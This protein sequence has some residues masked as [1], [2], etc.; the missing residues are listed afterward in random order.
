MLAPRPPALLLLLVRLLLLAP[1]PIVA[2]RKAEVV[3]SEGNG[4]A[5]RVAAACIA[6]PLP[7]G[8]LGDGAA[9]SG[10]ERLLEPVELGASAAQNAALPRILHSKRR[11]W[12]SS[13]RR[14]F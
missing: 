11:S 2:E 12:Y 7:E 3:G 1:L 5:K 8:E 6:P 14:N 13:E 4:S 9:L 10:L